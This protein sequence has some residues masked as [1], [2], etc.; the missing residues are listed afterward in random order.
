MGALPKASG[1]DGFGE[2][3]NKAKK[4][5]CVTAQLDSSTGTLPEHEPSNLAVLMGTN[6]IN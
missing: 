5:I 4:P 1:E 2:E 3:G 6:V